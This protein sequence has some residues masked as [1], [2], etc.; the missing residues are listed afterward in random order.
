MNDEQ[1]ME[2][3]L[4]TNPRR[5]PMK[6]PDDVRGGDV[7]PACG[8]G[9]KRIARQSSPS[10]HMVKG[11][12]AMG[13]VKPSSHLNARSGSMALK[14][15]SAIV[16]WHRGNGDVVRHELLTD[17]VAVSRRAL[18]RAVQPYRQALRAK[19]WATTRFAMPGGYRSTSGTSGRA[20]RRE[21]QSIRIRCDAPIC[22]GLHVR[23]L[24]AEKREHWC[25][26]WRVHSRPSEVCRRKC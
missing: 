23:A 22:A 6:T 19:P 16:H 2:S 24:R 18:Q 12:M 10:H 1:I 17:G 20:R 7:A 8:L 11:Y 25:Q 13:R 15:D 9:L 4:W 5:Q 26:D 21:H 14:A 3:S